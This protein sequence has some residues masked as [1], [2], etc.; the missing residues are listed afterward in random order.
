MGV[1]GMRP[2]QGRDDAF[3]GYAELYCAR[4]TWTPYCSACSRSRGSPSWRS[5][6]RPRSTP[7]CRRRWPSSNARSA[8]SGARLWAQYLTR[9]GPEPAPEC[10]PTPARAP[11]TL[12]ADP[13]RDQRL[14]PAHPRRREPQRQQR[15]GRVHPRHR[16][17]RNRPR[18][19]PGPRNRRTLATRHRGRD[20]HR[21]H[22]A[23][24]THPQCPG[25][26][27]SATPPLR[28]LK[29]QSIHRRPPAGH[30][31]VFQHVGVMVIARVV[32][33]RRTPAVTVSST[34]LGFAAAAGDRRPD[35]GDPAAR[36]LRCGSRRGRT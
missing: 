15:R 18:P 22:R 20:L 29:N 26:P 35:A 4:S 23:P 16:P 21:T 25:S 24:P 28:S 3:F 31:S 19:P 14:Q 32:G 11:R 36:K 34:A 7:R 8:P 12:R 1:V 27:P 5:A 6:W 33:Q 13:H 17:R 9:T 30:P 10:L 2:D